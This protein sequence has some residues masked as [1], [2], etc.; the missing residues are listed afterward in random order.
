MVAAE[1]LFALRSA[2]LQKTDGGEP[3]PSG[4]PELATNSPMQVQAYI[5]PHGNVPGEAPALP[6]RTL[7]YNLLLVLG[8]SALD[9]WC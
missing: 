8:D 1:T 2:T 3:A 5:V 6:S 7:G 9:G 4:R